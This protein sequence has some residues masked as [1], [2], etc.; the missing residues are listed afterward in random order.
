MKYVI[1]GGAGHISR[2]IVENLLKAGHEV[3]II[4]SKE[5]NAAAIEAIG[6]IPAVGSVEDET[7][8]IQAFT[9]ADAVYTMVPPKWDAAD[10]VH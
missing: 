9:G 6:A 10:W 7:F 3:T 5:I 4:T 2:P 1:T 8:I